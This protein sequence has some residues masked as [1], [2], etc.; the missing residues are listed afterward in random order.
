MTV[1]VPG[2]TRRDA[3]GSRTQTAVAR[4][5][6][7]RLDRVG[8]LLTLL[9]AYA[10]FC[11]PF[12]LFRANRITA[13]KEV[14]LL[15]LTS[16]WP[17]AFSDHAAAAISADP[18]GNLFQ[19]P[20]APPPLPVITWHGATILTAVLLA[21]CL[22]FVCLRSGA[23]LRAA[24]G[25]LLLLA[26]LVALGEAPALLVSPTQTFARVSPGSGAWTLVF[27]FSIL[28][29]DALAKHSLLPWQRLA[30][31]AGVLTVLAFLF[32]AGTWARLSVMQEYAARATTFWHEA[33]HHLSIV[34]GAVGAALVVGMPLGIACTRITALRILMLPL[35]NIVQTIPS[36]ALFGLLMAPLGWLALH[37]PAMAALGV[38]GIGMAPAILA[39]FLYSLLPLTASVV[40][41]IGEVPETLIEAANGMGMTRLQRL[42][43]I[44][45][46]F[47][48]PVLLSGIRIVL[49]QNIGLAAV[50]ALIGGG[51]FGTF[52]FQG[53]G[54]SA[55]DLVL[56]GAMP[57]LALALLASILFSAFADM[58]RIDGDL[59][60]GSRRSSDNRID[61]AAAASSSQDDAAAT[62][63]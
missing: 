25:G 56:L 17:P 10:A 11:Q 55:T 14:S 33:R 46:P 48:L 59:T 26:V 47:A 37:S 23:W 40:T 27:A 7:D 6:R 39:L 61:R 43:M 36:M 60:T 42:R 62:P 15:A 51:G 20:Q 1:S 63:Y 32:H 3:S 49:V 53:L 8:M 5:A 35:L 45:F 58:S 30:V 22:L 9:I 2:N 12:V 41:G 28:V 31:L 13:G 52:I 21:V 34:G 24:V 50:G 44:E 16:A 19:V 4:F 54:Q 57:T 18:G 29:T 38:R